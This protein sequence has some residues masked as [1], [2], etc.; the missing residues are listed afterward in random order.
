MNKLKLSFI[1]PCFNVEKYIA[2]CLDSLYKQDIPEE[3]YE[4]IC[5]NDCS[6]DNL[7][8]IIL[9]YQKKHTNLIFIEHEVNKRQGGARNTGLTVAN[10]EYIWFV[11]PD[12]YI[13]PNVTIQLLDFCKNNNLDILQ[14]NYDKVSFTGEYQN[15]KE[16]VKNSTVLNGIE[17][18]KTLG[19]DFLNQY[20]LSV[21]SR[22]IKTDFLKKNDIKFIENTI[23]EDL[24]FSLRTTLTSNRIL[25]ISESYY[26]YRYNV[27]NS[28]MSQ[29]TKQIT[30][31]FIFQGCFIIGKAIT[32]IANEIKIKDSSIS[33]TLLSAGLYRINK[34]TKPILKVSNKERKVFYALL[35]ENMEL[36]KS[37]LEYLSPINK[38]LVNYGKLSLIILFIIS[39]ILNLFRKS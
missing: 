17:F 39:P 22:L 13:K 32:E 37:I 29:I 38:L 20:D 9:D 27:F 30:G 26:F 14:F 1:L 6:P 8:N 7:R 18:T 16:N 31:N 34:I 36:T 2:E 11:D 10:G 21:W 23:F 12:D 19:I 33:N 28:T 24:E 3:E 35:K 4:V 15:K 5:V 25:S